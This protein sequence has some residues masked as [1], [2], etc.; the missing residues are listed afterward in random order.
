MLDKVA[1][2]RSADTEHEEE[3]MPAAA[4]FTFRHNNRYRAEISLGSYQCL[5]SNPTIAK[6]M[7]GF[8]FHDVSVSGSWRNRVAEATWANDN[9]TIKIRSIEGKIETKSEFPMAALLEAI[10]NADEVQPPKEIPSKRQRNT[11]PKR[12]KS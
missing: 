1:F 12:H 2:L 6:Q 8:G 11:R 4:S 3:R 5:I 7:Q 10:G 9:A